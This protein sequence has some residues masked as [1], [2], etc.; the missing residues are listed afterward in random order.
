LANGSIAFMFT[1]EYPWYLLRRMPFIRSTS[2]P[3]IIVWTLSII[4]PYHVWHPRTLGRPWVL[5]GWN[6]AAGV[7]I[8]GVGNYRFAPDH[9]IAAPQCLTVSVE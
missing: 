5:P 9:T 3:P 6:C 1:V 2:T 4:P 8:R 7:R